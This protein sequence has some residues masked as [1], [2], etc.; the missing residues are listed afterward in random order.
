MQYR[1]KGYIRF[2]GM[3]TQHKID[4]LGWRLLYCVWSNEGQYFFIRIYKSFYSCARGWSF[5]GGWETDEGRQDRFL[6]W[7]ITSSIDHSTLCYLQ[8]PRSTS[9]SSPGF[10][11]RRPGMGHRPRGG[12]LS[13][14]KLALTLAFTVSNFL[15]WRPPNRKQQT[16][17]GR[18]QT[19]N[20][21]SLC[22]SL[23][24]TD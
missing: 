16:S 11:N 5:C 22:P 15:N 12:D 10:Y 4:E 14:C 21:L 9:A 1:K 18:S 20:W 13:D 8:D 17:A 19:L 24:P 6:Y 23:S 2:S 7:P 3:F